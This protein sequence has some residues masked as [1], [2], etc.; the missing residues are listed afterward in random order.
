VIAKTVSVLATPGMFAN[1][2]SLEKITMPMPNLSSGNMG[3]V[4]AGLQAGSIDL[5]FNNDPQE[6]ASF[7][8]GDGGESLKK[9]TMPASVRR[10]AP[11]IFSTAVNLEELIMQGTTPPTVDAQ[12]F[13][14]L[15]NPE[16]KIYV[17]KGSLLTYQEHEEKEIEGCETDCFMVGWYNLKDKFLEY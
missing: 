7:G 4:L 13:S 15:T 14:G 2:P 16:L 11:G 6:V 9:L 10:C 8:G 17:P 12:A 5:T 3:D 1:C